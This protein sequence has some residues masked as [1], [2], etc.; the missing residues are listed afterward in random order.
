MGPLN[1]N[2]L[3]PMHPFLFLKHGQTLFGADRL[4]I[5]QFS[6]RRSL[7]TANKY[8]PEGQSN[9]HTS[10]FRWLWTADPQPRFVNETDIGSFVQVSTKI[11]FNEH[12][13][14]QPSYIPTNRKAHQFNSRTC[15]FIFF[16]IDNLERTAVSWLYH[17]WRMIVEIPI[18]FISPHPSQCGY[19]NPHALLRNVDACNRTFTSTLIRWTA[20]ENL[21][22]R[23]ELPLWKEEKKQ[24][25]EVYAK[26]WFPS[27]G[28]AQESMH[29]FY[30]RPYSNAFASYISWVTDP[31]FL[32]L[33]P[34]CSN[35]RS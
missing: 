28:V 22:I 21:W 6:L 23:M 17:W 20:L 31:Y 16:N 10:L 9:C 12:K 32:G 14:K 33:D 29:P 8:L 5:M 1:E 2:Q 15:F 35:L 27:S 13:V 19:T 30:E 18:V 25:R 3:Y 11:E 7:V 34:C 26:K 4:W 24:G